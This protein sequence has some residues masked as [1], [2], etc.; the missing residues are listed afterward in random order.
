MKATGAAGPFAG[1]GRAGLELLVGLVAPVA[2]YYGLRAAGVGAYTAL[3]AGA[4]VP[5]LGAVV[6]L[7]RGRHVDGLMA[8]FAAMTLLGLGVSLVGGGPRFLLAREAGITGVAGVWFLVSAWTAR[9]L[10]LAFSRPLLEGLFRYP[11]GR[12]DLLWER[13]P[14]FRRVWRVSSVVFGVGTL[15]DAAARVAMAY[16][17]P[18][19]LVPALHTALYAVTSVVVLAV[20]NVYQ[21]RAGLWT[22]LWGGPHRHS[23]SPAVRS[24]LHAVRKAPSDRGG[25]VRHG[26]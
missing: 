26:P 21:A 17:L 19:N 3:I 15:A 4:V 8:F 22:M 2:L 20:V 24:P 23:G 11:P 14:R 5:A 9:P 12:W 25:H 16:A 6:G 10:A 1:F 7:V 18:V 13:E